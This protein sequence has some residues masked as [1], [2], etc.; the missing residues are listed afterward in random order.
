MIRSLARLGIVAVAALELAGCAFSASPA[1]GLRFQAPPG[2]RPSPGIMG[3]MQFWQAPNDDRSVLMLFRSPKT[4]APDELFTNAQYRGTLKDTTVVRRQSI[5]ICGHQP[6]TYVEASGTSR[7]EPSRVD[8][9]ATNV[10]GASYIAMYV[11]PLTDSPDAKAEA[12]LRSLCA[13][14]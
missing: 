2:W 1:E 6:A 9:V 8:L 4:I 11:R 5:V 12:A 13:K 10:S 14:S 7:G 3:F